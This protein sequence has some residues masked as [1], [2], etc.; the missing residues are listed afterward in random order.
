MVELA[1]ALK[2]YVLTEIAACKKGKQIVQ[3]SGCMGNSNHPELACGKHECV[4]PSYVMVRA[5]ATMGRTRPKPK[6]ILTRYHQR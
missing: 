4:G 1:E 2:V 6:V 5:M 3:Q